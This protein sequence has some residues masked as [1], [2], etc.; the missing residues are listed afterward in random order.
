M[1]G[2]TAVGR[3]AGLAAALGVAAGANLVLT[4]LVALTLA[5]FG[6]PAAGSVA[7]GAAVGVTGLAFAAIAAVTAQVAQSARTANGIAATAIGAAFVVRGLGDALG[8]VGPSGYTVTSAWPS[9]LSPIGWATRVHPFAGD[10]W[11]VLAAPLMLTCAGVMTAFVLTAHRDVGMGMIAARPGPVRA[12]AR[13][14]SPLAAWPG[15]YSVARCSAGPRPSRCSAPGSDPSA[16]RSK[17]R[18]RTTKA[19]RTPSR[20]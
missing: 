8:R 12:A 9:W 16:A 13:L 10:R 14:L 20:A 4:A 5:G 19:P 17:T 1:I 11:W 18:W 6:E 15:A 7:A 3:Y 2:A